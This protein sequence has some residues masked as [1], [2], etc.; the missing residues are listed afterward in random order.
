ME[1]DLQTKNQNTTLEIINQVPEELLWIN[2]FNSKR[3]RQTYQIATRQFISF[4]KIK[5]PEELRTITHAHIIAFKN[6]LQENEQSPKTVNNRLSALSSLFNHL[7]EHQVVT[8][9]PVQSVKRM[10]INTDR[11]EAKVL[12]PF[13]ARKMIKAP[14]LSKDRGLRDQ[15]ILGILFFTGCR[16]SELCKLKVK[17]F[18]EEQ[19]FGILDFVIKGGKRNRLAVNQE[20]QIF[21]KAYLEKSGHMDDKNAPL[22]LPVAKNKNLEQMRFISSRQVQRLWKNYADKTNIQGT[23]PHSARATF[24]TQ[25]LENNCSLDAVQKSVGHSQ[26]KTTQMYDKRV[27]KYRESASFAVRY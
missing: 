27:A 13:E 24:I 18:Y 20:L 22:I 2:N 11:V 23:T 12:T 6:H 16:V 9:N 17:D 4:L 1:K 3:S 5:T 7:I 15:A 19:G 14:D 21:L 10:R 25:A 26:I 8:I